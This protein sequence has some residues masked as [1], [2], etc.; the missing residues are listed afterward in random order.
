MERRRNYRTEDVD[1]N[2][3]GVFDIGDAIDVARSDSWDDNLPTGCPGN[4]SQLP[5]DVA[6]GDKCY[7]GLRNWN[8]VRPAVFD[9]GYAFPGYK[10]EKGEGILPGTYIVQAVPPPGYEIV[11]EEEQ[12]RRFRRHLYAEPSAAASSLRGRSH[13]VPQYLSLFPDQQIEVPVGRR[14]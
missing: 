4:V 14:V 6:L 12:E 8:Q 3:N 9:G 13:E 2:A 11:K 7:D 5:E 1:H 10:V